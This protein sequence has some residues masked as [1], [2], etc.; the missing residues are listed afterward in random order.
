MTT[1]KQIVEWAMA[2]I[3]E[4][5]YGV[6]ASEMDTHCWRCGYERYTE[7]CHVIPDALDGEDTPSNYR[8]LCPDCH[9][10]A[11]N[12]NDPDEMDN[13]IRRTNVGTYER[14]WEVRNLYNEIYSKTIV[15]WG[16]GNINPSTRKWMFEQLNKK[17]LGG[18]RESDLK[19][20]QL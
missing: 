11:P 1:K 16:E 7:R 6:D 5:E 10:E 19:A 18:L 2:N 15:H 20:F 4:L 14:F 9:L 13:W 12:V 17:L 3:C 8:L